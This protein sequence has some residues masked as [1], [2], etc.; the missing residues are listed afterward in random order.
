MNQPGMSG[1]KPAG[2][3]HSEG[4]SNTQRPQ[5]KVLVGSEG[6]E[7]TAVRGGTPTMSELALPRASRGRLG[8][9]GASA[10]LPEGTRGR[11]GDAFRFS[12]GR[13]AD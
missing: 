4:A 8:Q 5:T 7:G 9:V 10:V 2:D 13:S 6:G 1:G 12:L 11:R 3:P